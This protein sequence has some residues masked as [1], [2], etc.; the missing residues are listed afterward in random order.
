MKQ[1]TITRIATKLKKKKDI[2]EVRSVSGDGKKPRLLSFK[3][4][5]KS[6]TPDVV[7]IY[8]DKK[9]LFSVEGKISKRT[10]SDTIAKWILFSLEARRHGGKFYLVVPSNEMD[11]CKEIIKDKQLSANLMLG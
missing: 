8:D 3:W 5:Q 11:Y 7:A 4:A 1:K 6:Y 10:I 9:D 2:T